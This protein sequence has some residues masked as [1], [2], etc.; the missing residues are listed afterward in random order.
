[1]VRETPDGIL[2]G[3][4]DLEDALPAVKDPDDDAE[5][6]RG[7]FLLSCP[8]DELQAQPL[9]C[10]KQVWFRISHAADREEGR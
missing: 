7:L 6:G 5:G 2:V 10:G 9:L 4:T 8:A 3:V 1:M